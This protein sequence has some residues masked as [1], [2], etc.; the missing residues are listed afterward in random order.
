MDRRNAIKLGTGLAAGVA[1]ESITGCA[2][3]MS[4]NLKNAER[5][6]GIVPD[7]MDDYLAGLDRNL[8]RIGESRFV[9]GFVAKATGKP[10]AP[11]LRKELDPSETQ[12]RGMLHTLL[13]TQSFRDLSED[14]RYHPGMQK[15]MLQNLESIDAS[16]FQV[17]DML[18]NLDAGQREDMRKFLK[19]N[20]DMA[21][22]LAETLDEQAA[23]AGVSRQSRIK[24]RS[25]M[26]QASFRL[27]NNA[28]GV[29]ID[30]YV[31]KV[32]KASEPNR[33]DILASQ[34]MA[35]VGGDAFWQYQDKL[36][37]SAGVGDPPPKPGERGIRIGAKLLG[38]G[39]LTLAG[40][41]L[42]VAIG[43]DGFEPLAVL[44]VI[45]LTVGAILF[46]IGFLTL[47]FSA[48]IRASN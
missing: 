8:E 26:T 16:V 22:R 17:S 23:L 40:S 44:G 13:L 27:R 45:G 47:I 5:P 30:E 14:G 21:I 10:F 42:A 37:A 41:G 28:P 1:L 19:K 46:A 9:E 34:S 20:P 11:E 7:D 12:F 25:M 38:I 2:P 36:A 43:V 15:R 29:V 31:E 6:R 24:M 48:L 35:K 39:V 32:R 33:A 3:G 4:E 18:E